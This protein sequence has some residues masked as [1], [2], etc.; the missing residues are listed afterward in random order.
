MTTLRIL[1]TAGGTIVKIDDVRHIGNFSTGSFPAK[2]ANAALAKNHEVIYL[3]AKNAKIP[4]A[5]RKLKRITYETYD[6][7]V[8]EL[9]KVLR[10]N[11][12]DIV[13]LAAAVSDY[14]VRPSRGKI[15]SSKPR[16]ILRLF[17]LPKVIKLVKQWSTS[18]LFQVGF[19][20]LSEVTEKE[21]VEAAYKSSLENRSDLT[22]ANDLA[23][24]KSRQREVILVTPER[25]SI[26]LKEP[27]L[28]EKII[29][30]V[31]RRARVNHFK[32]ISIGNKT[33]SKKYSKEMRLFRELCQRLSR[34]GLMPDFFIGAA[35][36][37]GS[38]ALR[39][40]NNSF[41]ITARGS[42]KKNLRPD[43][44]VRVRKVDWKKK[45]ITVESSHDKK[46]SFNAVLVSA[47][48]EK[49]PGVNAV[50]HTHSFAKKAPVTEFPYTPGT[51]EYATKP[52]SLF[53]NNRRVINLKNH[54]LIA[55]GS[56]LKETVNYVLG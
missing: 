24:I 25:G 42:N 34:R 9:K 43:D 48:F 3:H 37:H 40:S 31:E 13:F 51:F 39:T 11:K 41:L 33:I 47:I 54:G 53:K 36:G 4:S 8:G 2:I 16:L 38:V 14:G 32:T 35:S 21:L 46:A 29:E 20:L 27:N 1:V 30:F 50:V 49:F 6:D 7:Y 52:L 55:I 12:I 18:P 44:I 17:P 19:K 26:K 23:K 5:H 22:I 15:S 45:E 56:D 28:A 10:T